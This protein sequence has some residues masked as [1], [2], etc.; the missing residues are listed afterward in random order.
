M[1]YAGVDHHTKTSHITVV[2]ENGD[3]VRRKGISSNGDDVRKVLEEF[4]EPIKAVLEAGYNWGKMY[5]WLGEVADEVVLAHPTKVRAIAEARIK[6]DKIDSLT[7]AHLLKAD[8][9]PEAYA[10]SAE[11]RAVKRVLR[12]R[13]FLVRVQTMFKNRIHATVSQH[14]VKKPEVTDL[15]GAKGT[16]WLSGIDL[17][18]PDNL[19]L[20]E[21]LRF[22]SEVK[23]RIKATE[24][25]I[26]ELSRGDQAVKLLK[27]IPGIGDFFSVLIRY[28]V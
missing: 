24:G 11:T 22:L 21:D 17:P 15:F 26:R 27:S 13:M 7:L 10:C 6:N 16:R 20:E 19:I 23:T 28:E 8:L 25:L 14:D 12:Q 18:Y 3:I 5:D 2:D 1:L 4:N 9:I